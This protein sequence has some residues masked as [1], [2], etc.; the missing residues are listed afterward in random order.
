MAIMLVLKQMIIIS[1]WLKQLR[2]LVLKDRLHSTI[3][4]LD[5]LL[6]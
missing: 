3:D 5:K 1:I 6:A 4:I 2:C